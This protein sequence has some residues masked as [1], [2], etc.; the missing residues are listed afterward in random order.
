MV[1]GGSGANWLII[2]AF[3]TPLN[4]A[5]VDVNAKTLFKASIYVLFGSGSHKAVKQ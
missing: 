2:N 1:T 5:G 4:L 3:W